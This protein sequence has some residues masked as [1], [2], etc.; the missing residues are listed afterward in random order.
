MHSLLINHPESSSGKLSSRMMSSFFSF[1]FQIMH[2]TKIKYLC[3]YRLHKLYGSEMPISY[4]D[5]QIFQPKEL[6]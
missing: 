5:R 4:P 2:M 6:L 3:G 1:S